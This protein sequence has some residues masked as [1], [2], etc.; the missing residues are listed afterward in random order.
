MSVYLA[1]FLTGNAPANDYSMAYVL[2]QIL[3]G[4]N[5]WFWVIALLSLGRRHLNFNNKVLQYANEAAYPFYILQQTVIVFIGF[6]VVQ[7][8]IG[9]T[10]KILWISTA[11]LVVT[12]A[13]YDLFVKRSGLMR[14]LFGMNSK[15]TLPYSQK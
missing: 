6:Y 12:I 4:F 11:T 15:K 14:F 13:L 1:L 7:W 9:V 10:E 8:N 2:Y 5:A 3:H